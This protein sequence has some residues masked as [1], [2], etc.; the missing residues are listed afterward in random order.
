MSFAS[1]VAQAKKHGY[2]DAEIAAHLS[3]DATLGA[4]IK[5][6]RASGYSDAEIVAYLGRGQE[7]KPKTS[8][9]RDVVKSGLTGLGQGITSVIGAKGDAIEGV[10]N[11]LVGTAEKTGMIS[12]EQ[13]RKARGAVTRVRLTGRVPVLGRVGELVAPTSAELNKGLRL[14]YV[15]ET[16]AGGYAKAV[17]QMAPNAVLPGSMAR[18]AANVLAPALTS[19]AAGQGAEVLGASREG[20]AAARIGGAVA[21]GLAT[22]LKV[23]SVLTDRSPARPALKNQDYNVLNQRAGDYRAAGIE[24]TLVDVVDDSGRGVIRAAASR[25]TPGRQAATDFRDARA[26]NL[27]DRIGK[28]ARRVISDDPRTPDQIRD[29]LTTTRRAMANEEYAG[30]YAQKITLNMGMARALEGAPGRAAM[31]RARRAAEAFDNKDQIA[32]IDRL[33]DGDFFTPLSAGTVDR[34][35]IAMGER[36]KTATRSGARDIGAG[37]TRRESMIDGGLEGVEGLAPARANYAD[38]SR[39]LEAADVGEGFLNR[40]TDEFVAATRDMTPEQLAVARATARRAVE[41]KAG[42]SL[43]G[44]PGLARAIADAPEQQARNRSLLGPQDAGNLQNALR[45]E[46]RAVRNANDVA[47]RVGSQTQNKLQDAAVLEGA[48]QTGRKLLR[49]D[50]IGAGVDWLRSRGMSDRQA[51]ALVEA[52]IDPA[53]LDAVIESLARQIG[54]NEAQRFLRYRNTALVGAMSASAANQASSE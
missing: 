5:K 9:A 24:P 10:S 35:R 47:P 38:Y 30:P 1:Q 15:P 2:S 11:F 28:Q 33:L 40:N 46:E 32:E 45:L 54:R 29:S 14:N 48:L 16:S 51:Q 36:A 39:R 25:M 50:Y 44:A 6:A 19:E 37:L 18:R 49:Q 4:S 13:G 53:R 17:G 8:T 3:S 34:I 22:G 7:A 31:Q 27:P 52:S 41:R 43:G 20:A 21:G 23:R 26:L 42:E 12:P